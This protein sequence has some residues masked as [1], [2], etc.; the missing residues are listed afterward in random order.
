MAQFYVCP[1]VSVYTDTRIDTEIPPG[2]DPALVEARRRGIGTTQS[3]LVGHFWV[4]AHSGGRKAVY[5]CETE[6]TFRSQR[7]RPPSFL[8]R[9]GRYAP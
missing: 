8:G 4:V 7:E 9:G 6:L 3:Q 2:I 1:G 5:D